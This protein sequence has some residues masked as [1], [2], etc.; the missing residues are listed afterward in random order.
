MDTRSFFISLL[1]SH[2]EFILY[3]DILFEVCCLIINKQKQQQFFLKLVTI[4][5]LTD[6]TIQ[7]TSNLNLCLRI[8]NFTT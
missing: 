8:V 5:N 3:G 1:M 6:P 2:E 7:C 4:T